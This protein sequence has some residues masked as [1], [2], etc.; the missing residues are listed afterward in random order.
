MW[1]D[2]GRILITIK[3]V[4]EKAKTSVSTV[5]R[6]LSG[7][8]PVSEPVKN[9]VIQVVNELNYQPN[10]AA[11]SLKNGKSKILGLVIPNVRDLVFPAA[12]RG[13]EDSAQKHGYTVV[14]CNT[15]E[16]IAREK[17][18][19]EHLRRHLVDGFIF[20]TA[21]KGHEHLLKLK[22][23]GIPFVFLI[24][25]MGNG[26]DSVVVDNF[27]GAYDAVSYMIS[28]GLRNIALING[29]ID[30]SLYKQRLEGYKFALKGE[31][32]VFSEKMVVNGV[33][34]WEDAYQAMVNLLKAGLKI[35]GVFATSDSKAMGAIK[36]IKDYGYNIPEDISVMGFDNSD[37]AALADPPLTTV[38]QPFYKMGVAACERLLKLIEDNSKIKTK[39]QVLTTELIIR[40]SIK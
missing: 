16:D 2:R 25:N 17:F 11:Q 3:D 20:S 37:L 15:D 32:M 31:S 26:V 34:G 1:V 13:I 35:D 24:R 8:I 14:L 6:V 38:S 12:I 39:I 27:K 33:Y 9:K 22:E 5:S 10:I 23:Y 36:A 40:K 21:R 18:Y 29:P 28:R 7:K 4:A 19:I 30:I